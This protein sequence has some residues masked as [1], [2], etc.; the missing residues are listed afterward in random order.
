MTLREYAKPLRDVPV[1]EVDTAAILGVLQ[2]LWTRTP[3]TAMR[4]RLR[5]EAVLNSAKAQGLRTGENPAAW[6]GHLSHILPKRAA[7]ERSH[8]AAMAYAELPAF[9]TRLREASTMSAL[10]LEF[11]ILTAVRSG[12]VRGAKWNEI[13]LDAKG[14][15]IPAERM[16]GGREHRVPLSERAL[17]ILKTLAEVRTNELVFPGARRDRPLGDVALARVLRRLGADVTVH[18][19][20]SS[21]RDWAGNETSAAREIAEQCLAHASGDSTEQ[22]YR[23]GDALE[24]RRAL[25][26]AWAQFLDPRPVDNLVAFGRRTSKH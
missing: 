21:F 23:R 26:A 14:W 5:I 2:P 16:K 10:A 1:H 12:E 4:L 6:R 22:A 18:G 7:R 13:D 19:F 11:L 17:A 8:H 15:S 20:R 3:E 9:M 25:M 24:K